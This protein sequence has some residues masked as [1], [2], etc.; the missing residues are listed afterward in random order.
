MVKFLLMT[1]IIN[2]DRHI[3]IR[4][5]FLGMVFQ[6]YFSPTNLI[7]CLFGFRHISVPKAIKKAALLLS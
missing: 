3:S 7:E 5:G 2:Y 1:I 6:Q 4:K